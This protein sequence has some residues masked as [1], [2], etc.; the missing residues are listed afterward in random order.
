[1]KV[2]IADDR[3]DLSQRVDVANIAIERLTSQGELLDRG[4]ELFERVFDPAVLDRKEVYLKRMT[5]EGLGERDLLPFFMIAY[6]DI[7]NTRLVL[8]FLSSDLMWIDGDAEHAFLAVGNI[9]TSPLLKVHGVRGVGSLL[10]DAAIAMA[11]AEAV[12]DKR[13]LLCVATEAETASLGFW[14]K[15]GFRWPVGCHYLQP[16]LEYDEEGTPH[17][18]EVPE[19]LL[20]APIEMNPE[21]VSAELVRGIILA[22][23]ENWCLRVWRTELSPAA[24]ERA[25]Q[26]VM[27][28]VFGEVTKTLPTAPMALSDKFF[29]ACMESRAIVVADGR[30]RIHLWSPGAE[31]LFGYTAEEA[32]GRTLDLI[33]P[34]E[35]RGSHWAGFRA[36]MSSGI[37]KYEGE[38]F[39]L[40][41]VCKDGGIHKFSA[42]L[43]FLFDGSNTVGG[44]VGVFGPKVG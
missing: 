13:G 18:R 28:H 42:R 31:Q 29:P 37:A 2:E 22:I 36:A 19:T 8:G 20:L 9:A 1:M 39:E 30:G 43:I 15:R 24:L 7:D 10:L 3:P 11:K 12:K 41:V 23:Y 32:I 17:Y 14:R 4:Y 40:P 44:A 34:E 38:S 27:G 16:P 35:E 21:S 25:E 6:A 5:P 33:V 26:Y